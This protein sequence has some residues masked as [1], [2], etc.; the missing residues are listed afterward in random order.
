MKKTI[1]YSALFSI[2]SSTSFAENHAIPVPQPIKAATT[3]TA[4]TPQ[5]LTHLNQQP[6]IQPSP[7]INCE[8]HL[9][10]NT[11]TIDQSLI[12]T[13]SEQAAIQSFDFNAAKLD[14]QLKALQ[15]CFTDQGWQSFNEALEKSG[16]IDAIRSQQ[17][18]VSSKR[19]GELKVT[20]SKDNEWNVSIPLQVIYQNEKEKV[21]QSLRV[22]LLI[23]RQT[24]GDLGIM[25]IIATPRNK[26]EPSVSFNNADAPKQ[27]TA[28][29]QEQIQ[30]NNSLSTTQQK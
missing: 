14:A 2:V 30:T 25:Q 4:T 17:L 20:T 7:T 12:A 1:L 23:G 13:W 27:G 15:P 24:S 29:Q 6:A 18:S 16:N 3:S 11:T 9:A 19:D 21:T 28:Q 26:Q 10:Q 22:D 5:P 8:Y